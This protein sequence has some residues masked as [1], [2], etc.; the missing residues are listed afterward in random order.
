MNT[1]V[2]RVM[3]LARKQH[4]VVAVWQMREELRLEPGQIRAICR[5]L[6][7]VHQAV[8]AVDELSALGWYRAA[9]LAL[10]A[11]AAISHRSALMLLGLRPYKPIPIDVSVPGRGGRE[12]RGG[13][14]IHRPRVPM[15]VGES[16]G[17]PVTSPAQS[18]RD[19]DLEP[20]ALYR[21]LEE[22]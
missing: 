1:N 11:R 10:G 21:A 9:T 22:A 8:Y 14:E 16:H 19:A 7:R 20:Y 5:R 17:I 3:D 4:G 18:L 13:I 6:T 15:E 2:G 12:R